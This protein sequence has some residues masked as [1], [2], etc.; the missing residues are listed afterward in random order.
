[1]CCA[2]QSHLLTIVLGAPAPF[3]LFN[4][5]SES[6]G[7]TSAAK[8]SLFFA[9]AT[10]PAPGATGDPQKA[11]TP[12]P[13]SNTPQTAP[14]L[15]GGGLFNKTQQPANNNGAATTAQKAQPNLFAALGTGAS[16]TTP[17]AGKDVT[18]DFSKVSGAATSGT[19]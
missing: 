11:A 10:A 4:K 17:E 12:T 14:P 8:P 15:F 1:M 18:K 19:H 16:S 5:P 6:A 2:I 13:A 9:G 3:N 7:G